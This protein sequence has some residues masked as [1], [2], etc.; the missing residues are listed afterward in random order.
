M[1]KDMIALYYVHNAEKIPEGCSQ[2]QRMEIRD[3][4]IIKQEFG[5][6]FFDESAHLAMDLLNF[7]KSN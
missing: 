6:G 4:G 1:D 3:D 2:I 7:K 5:S